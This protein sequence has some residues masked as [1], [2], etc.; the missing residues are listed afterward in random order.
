MLLAEVFRPVGVHRAADGQAVAAAKQEVPEVRFAQ[1]VLV[2]GLLVAAMTVAG[3]H[4]AGAVLFEMAAYPE[5]GCA[6][7]AQ[8]RGEWSV[9]P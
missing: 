2:E 7:Q 6:Q 8:Q 1:V 4:R 5:L 9:F 3:A